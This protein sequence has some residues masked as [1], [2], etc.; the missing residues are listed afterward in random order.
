M[1]PHLAA[2]RTFAPNGRLGCRYCRGDV[3]PPKSSY[4]SEPC[5]HAFR[6]V[7]ENEYARACV[8]LRDRGVCAGCGL[9]TVRAAGRFLPHPLESPPGSM[10]PVRSHSWKWGAWEMDHVV[11][12]ARG[13]VTELSNLQTLC[14]LGKKRGCHYEKTRAFA[15]ERAIDRRGLH[16]P[17]RPPPE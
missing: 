9:D 15:A 10:Y 6:L 5:K 1:P 14:N 16:D 2:P 3:T 11:E 17:E 13:G 8:F 12:V 4:C 7:N